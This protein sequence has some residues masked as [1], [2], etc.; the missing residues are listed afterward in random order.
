MS[1]P[2]GDSP[3]GRLHTLVAMAQRRWGVARV[4]RFGGEALPEPDLLPTGVAALDRALGGLPR[5]ALTE[6]LGAPTSGMTTLA[7]AAAAHTQAAGALA[8]WVDIGG[9]FDPAY[10]A[11][12]GVDLAGLLLARPTSG[13]DALELVEALVASAALGLLVV[14]AL[15]W[16]AA[17]PAGSALLA[18]ALRRLT[19]MLARSPTALVALTALPIPAGA[20]SPLAQPAALRLHVA[21]G[22]WAV[23]EGE[24]PR[25][26]AHLFVMKRRGAADGARFA[27]PITFPRDW[28]LP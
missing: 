4:L 26:D 5:G 23:T 17:A 22:A 7:L 10:A 25:A 3:G 18:A 14:D 13:A 1:E 16:L 2:D 19:P 27:V 12:C 6:L 20:S 15:A 24:T 28:E 21:R 11:A 9:T 8:A